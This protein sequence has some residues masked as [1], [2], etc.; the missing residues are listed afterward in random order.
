M[1]GGDGP[2][3]PPL[4]PEAAEELARRHGLELV[5]QR[6]GLMSYL[7][8]VWRHRHL[9]WAMAR[10][11][12]V[13][14]HQDNYLGLLWSILNP[15]LMG[16]AYYLIF[17]I[18]IGTSGGIEN[19]VAFL[20][21]GLFTYIPLAAALT[22]GSKSVLK[23]SAMIR[24]LSFP[25]VLLPITTVLSEFVAALPAFLTLLLIALVS[26]EKPSLTWLL[27]PVTLLLVLLVSLG[28]GMITARV[29]NA[30]RDTANLVPLVVRILRY[31]SGVFFSVDA[32][33]ERVGDDAPEWLAGVL[34]YQPFAALL[35]LVREPLMQEYPVRWE[36]WVAA[37]GW[38]AG[39][40]V[41]GLIVFWRGEGTYGRS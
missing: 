12:F 26:G 31:V 30:V 23:K 2:L 40:L 16:V 20:T 13:S 10:G 34:Q 18:L 6:P 27:F 3:A 19:F 24:S 35:T 25:R 9:M 29:V 28:M 1:S 39:L 15:L 17:G 33:L 32:A 21:I 22:S 41:I 37:S 7:R 11:D 14:N 5:G 4:S 36:T 38:A 8:D